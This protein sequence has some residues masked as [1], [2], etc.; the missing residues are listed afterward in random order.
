MDVTRDVPS[1]EAT[2]DRVPRPTPLVTKPCVSVTRIVQCTA[3]PRDVDRGRRRQTAWPC[4]LADWRGWKESE[5]EAQPQVDRRLGQHKS[6][7][8]CL[9]SAQRLGGAVCWDRSRASSRQ[10]QHNSRTSKTSD[11]R[12]R[13]V[14]PACV[15]EKA[16]TSPLPGVTEAAGTDRQR[17]WLQVSHVQAPAPRTLAEDRQSPSK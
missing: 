11:R 5:L 6:S 12:S 2:A 10:A 1:G 9:P 4:R 3:R 17:A 16:G 13:H 7:C 8:S 15:T 14:P